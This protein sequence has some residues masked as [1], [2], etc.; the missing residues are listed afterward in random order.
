MHRK[1][2]R[3]VVAATLL[4][5]PAM[6]MAVAAD[7]GQFSASVATFV[8]DAD[9]TSVDLDLYW[10]P[11][12]WLGLGAGIGQSESSAELAD[13][14]GNS[15]R[16]SV[17]LHG[18][19]LGGRLSWRQW[20]DSGQFE[21][22]SMTAEVY[23]RTANGWQ[24]GAIAEQRDFN[25]DYTVTVLN[26]SIA[27]RVAFDG[28]GFG[29]QLAWYGD[30][31]GGYLRGVSYDYD[32]TLARVLTAA[33]TPNLARFPRIE[34][35]VASLLTRT[36]GAIDHDLSAGVERSFQRSGLRLDVAATRDALSGADSRSLSVSY[37]YSLTP[38]FELEGT[39]GSADS[40]D[41]DSVGFA[42]LALS[43]RN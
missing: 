20:Q 6:P 13:L 9:G 25:V 15:L 2:P 3:P 38:R 17:D 7:P 23:W 26:R 33:Q 1:P 34:A 4:L 32:E 36:A 40:D 31:W 24:L 11:T 30:T 12:A 8:D 37:R 21:S 42:G 14:E 19:S 41:L 28:Q 39:L 29:A 22:D 10:Q 5:L 16:A 27:R 18:E 35:L 43:F